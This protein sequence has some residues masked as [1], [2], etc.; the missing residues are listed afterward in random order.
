MPASFDFL[1]IRLL[2][3]F[4]RLTSTL[5]SKSLIF[6]SSLLLS[7]VTRLTQEEYA[8]TSFSLISTSSVNHHFLPFIPETKFHFSVSKQELKNSQYYAKDIMP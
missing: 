3:Y 7:S 1:K 5:L 4:D 8:Q 2:A 6:W